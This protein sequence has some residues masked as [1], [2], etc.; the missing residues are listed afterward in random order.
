M[1]MLN[2]IVEGKKYIPPQTAQESRIQETA[3]ITGISLI[4]SQP[5]AHSDQ[6]VDVFLVK[7]I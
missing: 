2:E 4:M 5:N 6:N 3:T 1:S 7:S